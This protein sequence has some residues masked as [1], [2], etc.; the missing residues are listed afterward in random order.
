MDRQGLLFLANALGVLTNDV[1]QNNEE[2]LRQLIKR[3]ELKT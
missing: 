3:Q 2:A 1:D